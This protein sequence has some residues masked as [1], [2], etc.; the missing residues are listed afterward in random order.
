MSLSSDLSFVEDLF[1]DYD[2]SQGEE[3]NLKV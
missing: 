2:Q 1:D 3:K